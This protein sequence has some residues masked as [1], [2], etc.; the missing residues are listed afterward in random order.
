MQQLATLLSTV[1]YDSHSYED[2]NVIDMTTDSRQVRPGY[3]FIAVPGETVD[4]R[5]FIAQSIAAGAVACLCEGD[6][7]AVLD[8]YAVPVIS[9]VNLRQRIG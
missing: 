5:D 8:E 1:G 7:T 2:I 3:L 4:G 6:V 9:V